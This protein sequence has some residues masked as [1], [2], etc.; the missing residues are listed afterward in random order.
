M[1]LTRAMVR[2]YYETHGS[3]RG[4][5]RTSFYEKVKKFASQTFSGFSAG[6]AE[7][8]FLWYS[9]GYEG[10][11]GLPSELRK[12]HCVVMGEYE[13]QEEIEKAKRF[14]ADNKIVFPAQMPR[15]LATEKQLPEKIDVLSELL[16]SHYLSDTQLLVVVGDNVVVLGDYLQ[17]ISC[18]GKFRALDRTIVDKV[19]VSIEAEHEGDNRVVGN[20]LYTKEKVSKSEAG[21]IQTVAL[22]KAIGKRNRI[23]AWFKITPADGVMLYFKNK[24]HYLQLLLMCHKE[25]I[26]YQQLM[27]ARG[28]EIHD[29]GKLYE[30]TGFYCFTFGE[31]AY[32]IHP[33]QTVDNLNLTTV[34]D[35]EQK[36][37]QYQAK[38]QVRGKEVAK[39]QAKE[40]EA[41]DE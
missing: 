4:I 34:S 41:F 14:L 21:K 13:S 37:T 5:E 24:L 12:A 16:A 32:Y 38:Q 20:T 40:M 19:L 35:L 39:L 1:I 36:I 27:R 7:N 28:C 11:S 17:Q 9:L 10:T 6:Q 31:N 18:D 2:N 23:P 29:C 3:F 22:E 25:G 30:C 26:S 33:E 15:T 8:E